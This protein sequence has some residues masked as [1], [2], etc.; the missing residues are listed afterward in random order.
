MYLLLYRLQVNALVVGHDLH[1]P[2]LTL[3]IIQYKILQLHNIMIVIFPIHTLIRG[4]VLL[5]F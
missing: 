3:H 4:H 2:T 5:L 1:G